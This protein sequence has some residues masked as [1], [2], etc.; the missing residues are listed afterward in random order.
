MMLKV[1]QKLVVS[2]ESNFSLVSV[3]S[4]LCTCVQGRLVS[5]CSDNTLHLWEINLRSGNSVL[6]E[7][8]EFSMENKSVFLDYL[9]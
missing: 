8:K 7:V 4:A 6:E 9:F 5:V 3:C 2:S 1:E